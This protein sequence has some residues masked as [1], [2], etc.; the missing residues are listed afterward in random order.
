MATFTSVP[1]AV[2]STRDD[3]ADSV[4]P[5]TVKR[6]TPSDS[7]SVTLTGVPNDAEACWTKTWAEQLEDSEG[8]GCAAAGPGL[9]AAAE[10]ETATDRGSPTCK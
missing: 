10:T 7:I 3:E 2:D 9:S 6:G 1:S 4:E 8:A 5:L